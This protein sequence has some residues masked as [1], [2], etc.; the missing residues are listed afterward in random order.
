MSF[1]IILLFFITASLNFNEVKMFVSENF[2]S[3]QTKAKGWKMNSQKV[4]YW[5]YFYKNGNIE[6]KGEYTNDKKSG[7]W[8]F[9]APN[10]NILKEGHF[11][12][13]IPHAWWIFYKKGDY[14]KEK[15]IYKNNGKTRYCLVYNENKLTKACKYE[16]DIFLQQWTSI[17][18]FKHDNPHF[19]F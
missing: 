12:N 18:S 13:G 2:P 14:T 1:K 16:N 8:F 3:G 9:Y 6:A 10:G 15:C 19:S 17:S 4:G 5:H 11:K 7:Y